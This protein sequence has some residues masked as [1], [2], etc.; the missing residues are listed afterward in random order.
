MSKSKFQQERDAEYAAMQALAYAPTSAPT[1]ATAQPFGGLALEDQVQGTDA[2]TR[3]DLQIP[4]LVIVQ[5]Q[6]AE[7]P[8][9]LKHIGQLFNNLTGEFYD[10]VTAV[11]LS[12]V[13][14]RAAFDR[15]FSRDSEPLCASDDAIMP[16]AEYIGRSLTDSERD[17]EHIIDDAGCPSCP[18]SK[19]GNNGETPLC[20]KSFTYAML[21]A[22][23]HFPFLFRA[24]RTGMSAARQLTRIAKT[25]GRQKYIK[26]STR[27]VKSDSGAYFVPVFST[28]GD[29]ETEIKQYA[30][31]LS[32]QVGNVARRIELTPEA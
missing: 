13:K 17:I 25:I 9:N 7:I 31:T 14:G 6:S 11:L 26:I 22:M 1:N 16:R 28:N 2:L 21:D 29:A 23:T 3:E 10:E 18:F 12:E 15:T 5:A 24:Q 30:A 4:H 8:D 27:E 20:A 19:F 32:S